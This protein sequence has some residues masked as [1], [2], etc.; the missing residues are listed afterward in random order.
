MRL[1]PLA[2]LHRP[3]L[4]SGMPLPAQWLRFAQ[5]AVKMVGTKS[6][7]AA[8]SLRKA[9]GREIVAALSERHAGLQHL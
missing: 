9:A 2:G 7:P 5:V 8:A 1:P 6:H 4:G 3:L